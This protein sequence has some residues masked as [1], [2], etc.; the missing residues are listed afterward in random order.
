M[1]H[2]WGAATDES[3]LLEVEEEKDNSFMSHLSESAWVYE[4]EPSAEF[5]Y[6]EF[7][8]VCTSLPLSMGIRS[9]ITILVT[10]FECLYPGKVTYRLRGRVSIC[11]K[12]MSLSRASP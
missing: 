11:K 1:S 6:F 7:G 9:H 3:T 4:D 2:I 5:S 12:A 10:V 8:S